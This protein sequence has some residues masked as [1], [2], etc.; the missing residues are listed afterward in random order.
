MKLFLSIIIPA[1]NEAKR[2]PT[3]LSSLQQNLSKSPFSWEIIVVS[4]GSTD[5][6]EGVVQ[7]FCKSIKNLN[8]IKGETN[9]GKGWAV[10]QG[11]LQAKGKWRLFMD[12]DNSANI[13]Q[14]EK[15]KSHLGEYDVV[16]GSRDMS[17]SKLVP[18]QPWSKRLLGNLGNLFIQT[19]LLP[20]CWDSQCGFKCFSAEAAENIFSQTKINRWG[21]DV[22]A[23]VLARKMGLKTKEVPLVW[24]ND[25]C[26]YVRLL[27]YPRTL[28]DI[29]KIRWWLWRGKYI[30]SSQ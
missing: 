4:D 22:E 13:D 28:L 5:S 18:P 14:F 24:A 30:V 21:F 29:L 8:L 12:A 25:P 7:E 26:S 23:L 2:L 9:Q 16:F 10:R 3:T 20:G 27:D 6:T 17:G 11:M 1:Y 19:L 15:I